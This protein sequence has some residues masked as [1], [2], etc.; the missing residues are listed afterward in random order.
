[1]NLDFGMWLNMCLGCEKCKGLYVSSDL[2]CLYIESNK[3]LYVLAFNNT[4][5]PSHLYETILE[6]GNN[7]K[8]IETK[9]TL[10]DLLKRKYGY[11]G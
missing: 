7:I 11:A 8:R 3:R 4:L 9:D 10:K 6:A 2:S 5:Y 1:M